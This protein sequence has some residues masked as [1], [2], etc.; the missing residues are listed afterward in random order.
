MAITLLAACGG[1]VSSPVAPT[2]TPPAQPP[3]V[4]LFPVTFPFNSWLWQ[5]LVY[6]AYDDHPGDLSE[7]GRVSWVFDL[8][9]IP[10]FYIRRSTPDDTMPGCG[11][12]WSLDHLAYME[13]MIPRLVEQ[14][15]GERYRGQ[16]ISGCEDRHE[17]GWITIV[18]ATPKEEPDL[19]GHCGLARIGSNPGRIWFNEEP[20][21]TCTRAGFRELLAHEVG[22]AMGF[23]HA[24]SGREYA[25][26]Y[27]E[28]TGRE[29][30]TIAERQH[31][32]Y[33]Y[34]R[35]RHAPYC[36]DAAT[37]GR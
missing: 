9:R 19:A 21:Y 10:H 13:R 6:N 11:R 16:I 2:P 4:I 34:K 17:T 27:D 33:A 14:L 15:T 1:D 29:G 24:P 35:G 30:F 32:Q 12:R 23:Y 31:A 18:S 28:W 5:S 7:S 36:Y 26:A 22:H 20:A 25:M 37:C 3:P 8:D